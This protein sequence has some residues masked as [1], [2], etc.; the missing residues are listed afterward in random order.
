MLRRCCWVGD[1]G[2]TCGGV[3]VVGKVEVALGLVDRVIIVVLAVDVVVMD[4]V[5]M[6][7]G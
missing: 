6:V 5:E 1:G 3:E 4:L 7:L 2:R